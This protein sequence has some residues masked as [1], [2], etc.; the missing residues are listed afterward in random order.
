MAC[1]QLKNPITGETRNLS[2]AIGESVPMLPGE[3]VVGAGSSCNGEASPQTLQQE[4]DSAIGSGSGDWIRDLAKPL[5]KLLGKEGCSKCEA[6]RLAT[7]AY[8]KLKDK[9]GQL[10]AL[11]IIK[12]LWQMSLTDAD[13]TLIRLQQYLQELN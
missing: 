10:E 3:I 7:N 2:V 1:L 6:R 9:H 12:E 4:L 8:G 11:R 5:A 13:A